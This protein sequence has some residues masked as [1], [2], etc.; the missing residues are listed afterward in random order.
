LLENGVLRWLGT[1]SYSI[2]LWHWPIFMLSRPGVDVHLP[3]ALVQA[4]QLAA[5][6]GLAELSYR[7]IES[8]IRHLGFRSG[9]RSW[10][11]KFN[12]WSIP[13][14]LGVVTGIICAGLLLIWQGF[15]PVAQAKPDTVRALQNTS[16]PTELVD[17]TPTRPPF[18]P[19]AR[20]PGISA[21]IRSTSTAQNDLPALP[22]TPAA[23][24][25]AITLI[26]DSIMQGATPMIEDAL[27]ENIFIDAARKRR[28]EDLP[29]LIESLAE[30]HNLGPVVIIHLGSN[31][32]FEG[33]IL[34]QI[35]ESLLAHQVK[36]TIFI[37]V[38]RPIGW[39]SYV[40]RQFAEGM[41]RWPQAELMDWD[42][43]AHSQQEWF[44]EDQTHLSYAG[45]RAYITAIQEK[46]QAAP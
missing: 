14:K 25:P 5:T 3:A 24:A 37:N 13:Q 22:S 36:R 34:D 40:N 4:G 29:A 32:P 7:W 27:G 1:R 43:I 18:V 26:G 38:H 46:L 16:S 2:Y 35:M 9:V 30:A 28:M 45:S 31:R 41:V 8:P 17:I 39:E 12:L 10:Q 23:S 42:A 6:L 33:A 44:I 15:Q 11:T 19:T 20:A 21:S